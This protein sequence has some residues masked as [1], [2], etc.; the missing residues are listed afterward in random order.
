[1]KYLLILSSVFMAMNTYAAPTCD[2]NISVSKITGAKTTKIVLQDSYRGAYSKGEKSASDILE[3]KLLAKCIEAGAEKC[4]IKNMTSK[5]VDDFGGI[6]FGNGYWRINAT[7][8]GTVMAGGITL[9]ESEYA[10]KR[11]KAICQKVDT[12][13]NNALNDE[14]SSTVFM[15]KLYMIKDKT[16]CNEVENFIFD[17]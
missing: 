1:M 15:E 4:T 13:I 8:E 7:V 17:S 6:S 14:K 2:L 16:N 11:Q 3:A 5:L 9:S 12:C 10:K